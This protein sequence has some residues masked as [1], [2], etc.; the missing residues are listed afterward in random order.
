VFSVSVSNTDDHLRNHGFILTE[1]GWVIPPA[2]DI[3]PNE[4]WTGLSLNISNNDN[5]LEY[6]LALEVVEYFRLKKKK[7][8][9]IM[10]DIKSKVNE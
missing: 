7:A 8:E 3:N 2:Y 6:D 9:E 10:N 5:S 1:Y 4:M